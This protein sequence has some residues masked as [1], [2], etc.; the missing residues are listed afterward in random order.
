MSR[1]QQI[2]NFIDAL[3]A[4]DGV[5]VDERLGQTGNYGQANVSTSATL[6]IEGNIN[7]QS[8]LIQNTGSGPVYVGFDNEV[9]PS[10]GIEVAAGGTYSDETYGGDVYVVAGSGT[11]DVRFQEV[12]Q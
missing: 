3:E 7:R 12:T 6:L 1:N 5:S 8:T 9:T 4:A 11:K 10:D 2:Q